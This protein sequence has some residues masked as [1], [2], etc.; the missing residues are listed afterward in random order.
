MATRG[1]ALTS[2]SLFPTTDA[3][4]GTTRTKTLS[5][6]I[7]TE[8]GTVISYALPAV[9]QR[10]TV[11]VTEVCATK[12]LPVL[13]LTVIVG[14]VADSDRRGLNTDTLRQ[15]SPEQSTSS[16][17]VQ[18]SDC[19]I[20]ANTWKCWGTPAR[21]GTVVAAIVIGLLIVGV[22]VWGLCGKNKSKDYERRK[23]RSTR[24][25]KQKEGMRKTAAE[26]EKQK[27][28]LDTLLETLVEILLE[29]LL[30]NKKNTEKTAI[31]LEE[32][33]H[34]RRYRSRHRT[35]RPRGRNRSRVNSTSPIEHPRNPRSGS[36]RGRRSPPHES[37]KRHSRSGPPEVVRETK[38]V[39]HD[40]RPMGSQSP[41]SRRSHAPH[42]RFES[43]VLDN[44]LGASIRVPER[45]VRVDASNHSSYYRPR[46]RDFAFPP[47]VAAPIAAPV[48]AV[49]EREE[50][51]SRKRKHRR[52]TGE[53]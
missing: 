19:P 30:E 7:K 38:T 50:D 29:A 5:T 20:W 26:G 31:D 47:P 21:S 40:R 13:Y 14:A 4:Y 8:K 22:I 16:E 36:Y 9:Q 25:S 41:P 43:N 28:L 53:G 49:I 33:S 2:A 6:R 3:Q 35:H 10:E 51:D 39:P 11:T 46:V 27:S 48:A 1:Y 42:L 37:T 34:R 52:S 12:T 18:S 32:G 15:I 23:R 24:Q 45:A 17:I 44:T